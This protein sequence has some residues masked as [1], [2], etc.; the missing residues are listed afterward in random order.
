MELIE[1]YIYAVVR[2]QPEKQRDDI[3]KELR[4]LIDDMLAERTGDAPA[5]ENDIKAVLK[6]LGKPS[7]LA[8]K[9]S[10][11]PR[12]L[13]GPELFDIYVKILKIVPLAAAFGTLIAIVANYAMTP[14]DSL[15]T[16]TGTVISSI[17]STAVEAFGMVTLVFAL[18]ERSAT[19]KGK[20]FP[21]KKEW[22]PADL[23]EIP[24]KRAVIKPS[25]P[26]VA[27]AFIIIFC[28]LFNLA[29]GLF[30]VYFSNSDALST[31][32]FNIDV[33]R[34]YLP[35]INI[36]FALS[37]IREILKLVYGRYDLKLAVA[38]IALSTVSFIITMIV[39]SNYTIWNPD[40]AFVLHLKIRPEKEIRNAVL[41]F[42]RVILGIFT[43]SY[44]V[45]TIKIIC[46][47]VG[48]SSLKEFIKRS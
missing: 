36:G 32:I 26:I 12:Y 48:T 28:I 35:L 41:I 22:D 10:G 5:S 29:P 33:F 15:S 23:P 34:S 40:F 25:Q 19:E 21:R 6:E 20:D 14:P 37:F 44:V 47:T 30:S 45:D 1:R 9:Y 46:K 42:G 11:K 7:E 13:I 43:F 8:A 2:L 3:E 4:S 31:P 24:K 27:I 18:I 39:F 16:A 17:F 38:A